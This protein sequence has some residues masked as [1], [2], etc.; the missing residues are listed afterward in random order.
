MKKLIQASENFVIPGTKKMVRER[1]F[2][3]LSDTPLKEELVMTVPSYTIMPLSDKDKADFPT[4]NN[5]KSAS[6]VELPAFRD[7]PEPSLFS[8]EGTGKLTVVIDDLVPCTVRVFGY[9]GFMEKEFINPSEA[10][11]FVK[12]KLFHLANDEG[13]GYRELL[14]L[15]FQ[16]NHLRFPPK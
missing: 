13:L 1:Q 5:L 4:I 15:G 10:L 7:W 9:A 12:V 14:M 3:V 6:V 16:R 8:K 11:E 2:M